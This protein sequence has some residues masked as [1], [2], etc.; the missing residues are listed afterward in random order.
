MHELLH[1]CIQV[2]FICAQPPNVQGLTNVLLERFTVGGCIGPKAT[3]LPLGTAHI[4]WVRVKTSGQ[5]I[6]SATEA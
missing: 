2:P 4:V 5:V 1:A 6:L 3:A